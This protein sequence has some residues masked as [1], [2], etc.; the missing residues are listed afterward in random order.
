[1]RLLLKTKPGWRLFKD[2]NLIGVPKYIIE[3]C[4]TRNEII[5]NGLWFN[6][7]KVLKIFKAVSYTHLRAHE[8]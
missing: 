7:K 2:R 1:M 5:M 8:T 3:H 6:K 4:S